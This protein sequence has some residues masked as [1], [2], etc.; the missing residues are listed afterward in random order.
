MGGTMP[1]GIKQ[2]HKPRTWQEFCE[3]DRKG[4]GSW[5]TFESG[6]FDKGELKIDDALSPL[7]PN[8][9]LVINKVSASAG[10]PE[11]Y[12]FTGTR[13]LTNWPPPMPLGFE[14]PS[15]PQKKP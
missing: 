3:A 10:P 7:F 14:P 5:L 11:L 8:E 12:P 2:F 4:K 6:M 1:A 9:E 13:P 15:Y